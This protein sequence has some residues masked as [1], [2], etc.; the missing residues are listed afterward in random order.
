MREDLLGYLLN[1]LDEPER[2][3]IFE[4]L[5]KDPELR[6]E[7]ETLRRDLRPLDAT[8]RDYDP[9]AGMAELTCELVE[10]YAER[11]AVGVRSE[12]D[13]RRSRGWKGR[14]ATRDACVPAHGWSA[15]DTIVAVGILLALSLI[16][17]PA[18]A[19]SRYLAQ[20]TQ[21]QEN[22]RQL[23]IALAGYSEQHNGFFPSIPVSGNRAVAGIYAPILLES[24]YLE[25]PR[26]VLCP[27]SEFVVPEGEFRIPRLSELDQARGF[28]LLA[29]QRVMGGSYGY[30][31]GNISDDGYRT[32]RNRLRQYFAL[33]A[34]APSLHLPGRQSG[35]HGGRGQ[36]VLFEDQHVEFLP[37]PRNEL[38]GDDLFRNRYGYVEAGLDEG[39]SVV[40]PSYVSPL[41]RY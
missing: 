11:N 21:C 22:L 16:F 19:R 15:A 30:T 6:Q 9:P 36:N 41:L 7:L 38:I 3:R 12:P 2:Q 33:L 20:V 34:D 32:P 17:F 8:N 39:D 27:G 28:R 31:L 37:S 25:N 23:G 10:A 29:L 13:S 35:N 14:F 4:T 1:A 18:M 24:Q 5:Q 26:I 40:V